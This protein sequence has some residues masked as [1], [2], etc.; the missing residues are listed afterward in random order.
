M[1]RY[2]LVDGEVVEEP[3]FDEWAEWIEGNERHIGWDIAGEEDDK[4]TVST[5]FLGVDYSWMDKRT[6][7]QPKP[8]LFETMVFGGEMDEYME[9]YSTLQEAKDGHERICRKVGIK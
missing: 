2:I 1:S 6:A 9:R 5:I 3:D 8:L 7:V 4:I